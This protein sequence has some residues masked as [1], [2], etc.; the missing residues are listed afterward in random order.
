MGQLDYKVPKNLEELFVSNPWW[1]GVSDELDRVCRVSQ[2]PEFVTPRH[3]HGAVEALF[4]HTEITDEKL[5]IAK[6]D[7]VFEEAKQIIAGLKQGDEFPAR[8]AELFISKRADALKE[9]HRC[10]SRLLVRVT[11]PS[12]K[13]KLEEAWADRKR[14]FPSYRSLAEK[15]KIKDLT[16]KFILRSLADLDDLRSR[17]EIRD[18]PFHETDYLQAEM[19]EG[20]NR[21]SRVD[22]LAYRV[23]DPLWLSAMEHYEPE[24]VTFPL[25]WAGAMFATS[26]MRA[27][28][29]RHKNGKDVVADLIDYFKSGDSLM[30]LENAIASCPLTN[31]HGE[32]FSE[33]VTDFKSGRFR[34]CSIALL[35]LIEGVVWDFAWWWNRDTGLAF[36]RN[37]EENDFLNGNFHLMNKNGNVIQT[38]PTIGLLLRHTK[39]GDE[40]YFEFLDF[41]CDELFA[42]RNPV[43]HGKQPDYGDEKKAAT[44]LFI[45]RCIEKEITEYFAKKFCEKAMEMLP[46]HKAAAAK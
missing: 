38:G 17:V 30:L 32:L 7:D 1:K 4:E 21:T 15:Y 40:F 26:T 9:I 34:A 46:A 2:L 13:E 14:P 5:Q 23:F 29:E 41:F 11:D 27:L 37:V 28:Y 44:L 8:L 16:Q 39:F 3:K 35:A 31:R 22:Y 6:G 18:Y 45:L 42:E 20:P 12:C 24:Y 43:L 25:K 19:G 10:F 33:I 36:D